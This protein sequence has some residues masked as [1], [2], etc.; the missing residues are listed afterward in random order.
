[1][2][3]G[4]IVFWSLKGRGDVASR[5]ILGMIVATAWLMRVETILTKF[6]DPKP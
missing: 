6:P 2:G 5:L 3:L 1:M 4:L